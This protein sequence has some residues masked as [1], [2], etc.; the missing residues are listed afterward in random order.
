[1][2]VVV[3]ENFSQAEINLSKDFGARNN[4]SRMFGKIHLAMIYIERV[5][6]RDR[7]SITLAFGIV[8]V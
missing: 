6:L 3:L 7:K 1:M 8:Q 5:D 4:M 2:V